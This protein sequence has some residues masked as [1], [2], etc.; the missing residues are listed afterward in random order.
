[1]DDAGRYLTCSGR[2]KR[3]FPLILNR[4]GVTKP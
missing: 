2:L 1:M 3:R 4:I